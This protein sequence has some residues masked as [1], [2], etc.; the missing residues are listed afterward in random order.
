VL[1]RAALPRR[2]KHDMDER[3]MKLESKAAG[4][5]LWQGARAPD[6]RLLI[7]VVGG[8]GARARPLAVVAAV[9]R[10]C[11]GAAAGNAHHALPHA[12]LVAT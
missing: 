5:M 3:A 6:Q 10:R 4:R 12:L 7:A 9:D 8:R 11:E 2:T 1:R